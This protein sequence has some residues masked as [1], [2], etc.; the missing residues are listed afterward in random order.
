MHHK[1]RRWWLSDSNKMQCF[2]VL[3]KP[4][5]DTT[6]TRRHL[7]KQ[8]SKDSSKAPTI[9]AMMIPAISPDDSF[10]LLVVLL[11]V[12][13]VL[14]TDTVTVAFKSLVPTFPAKSE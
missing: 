8:H 5:I 10:L 1:A 9:A 4:S 13:S 14:S 2:A 12:L 3:N 6:V 7:T 11:S